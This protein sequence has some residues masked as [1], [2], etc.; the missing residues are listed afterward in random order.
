MT[1]F[2][3]L[4]GVKGGPAIRPGSN[5]PTSILVSLGGRTILVDAGLGAA[6][7]VCDQGIALTALDAILVTHLH[8]D[9]Y[10]ELGPLLHTAWTAG[11]NR[12]LPVYGPPR[13]SSYWSG[14]LASMKDDIELRIADEGRPDL[15]GL[16]DLRPIDPTGIAEIGGVCLRAMENVHPPVEPSYALRLEA[17]GKSVVLS[18]DTAYMPEMEHFAKGADLLVHEALLTDGVDA[19]VAKVPNGDDRLRTHILRS[20]TAAEDV[21]R[22]ARDAGVAR[23]ALNHFVPDGLPGFA[24]A[25]WEAAVRKTWHGPLVLGRDGIRIEL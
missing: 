13:L 23:L 17:G 21:G 1:D 8:S 15:A 12:P 5:M 3:A 25:D 14:F 11:L 10:L 22:I 2:V 20:H 4:L 16:V 18:G 9:H 6:K 19:L 24:E 7:G